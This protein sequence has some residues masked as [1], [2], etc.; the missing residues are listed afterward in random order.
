MEESHLSSNNF[1][2]ASLTIYRECRKNYTALP[3]NIAV[4]HDAL[5]EMII[6]TNKSENFILINYVESVIAIF[7]CTSNLECLAQNVQDV[8]VDGTFKCCPK[9]FFQM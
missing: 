2:N 9:Y 8:F 3:K 6:E 7:S 5:K 4:L 1:K